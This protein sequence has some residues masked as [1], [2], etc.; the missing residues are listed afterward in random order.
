MM[1]ILINYKHYII[2]I[3]IIIIK[4]KRYLLI[5][6][7]INQKINK[8]INVQFVHYIYVKMIIHL[9][10]NNKNIQKLYIIVLMINVKINY[11]IYNVFHNIIKINHKE[12]VYNV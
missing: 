12:I 2:I 3:I 8:L 7:M 9:M 10:S 1:L 4:Y 6:Q 5:V 11:I